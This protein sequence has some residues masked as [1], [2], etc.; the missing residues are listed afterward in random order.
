MAVYELGSYSL[1]PLGLN[2]FLPTKT[3]ITAEIIQWKVL[4]ELFCE[5]QTVNFFGQVV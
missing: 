5:V 2:N 1:H 3:L 4:I